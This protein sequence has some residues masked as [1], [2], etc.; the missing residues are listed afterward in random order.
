MTL[1]VT[2]KTYY[3][4]DTSVCP[5]QPHRG[6]SV[7]AK[8]LPSRP[9]SAWYPTPHHPLLPS[10]LSPS[11]SKSLFL[12]FLLFFFPY[13]HLGIFPIKKNDLVYLFLE[14]EEGRE[15]ERERNIDVKETSISRPDQES[16]SQPFSLQ[17]NAHHLSH[18]SQGGIF[19]IKV[20]VTLTFQPSSLCLDILHEGQ[21]SSM[22]SVL[23]DASA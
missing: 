22:N 13:A 7:S 6:H 18:I 9:T 4:S 8:P 23:Q 2:F 5:C 10:F 20:S 12:S 15:K 1:L 21:L 11:S 16:N 17:D 19:P 3:C 14:T